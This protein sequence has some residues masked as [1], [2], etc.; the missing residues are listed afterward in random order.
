MISDLVYK[1][2]GSSDNL[3][4]SLGIQKATSEDEVIKLLRE[5]FSNFPDWLIEGGI[6]KILLRNTTALPKGGG[7]D[8]GGRDKP[9]KP[10][11]YPVPPPDSHQ[12]GG[13]D[14]PVINDVT[15]VVNCF[16][17]G[18]WGPLGGLYITIGSIRVPIGFAF[19][20]QVCLDQACADK[21]AD[22]LMGLG[23]GSKIVSLVSEII[24]K[25]ISA[26]TITAATAM[27]IYA[28]V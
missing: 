6:P 4:K 5:K 15:S 9:P 27:V 12:G 11:G 14:I 19:G 22:I 24:S 10:K 17:N 23:G 7:R 21:L 2:D 26:L 8:D 18:T 16:I 1:L 28:F 13:I 20:W 25:S 3:R